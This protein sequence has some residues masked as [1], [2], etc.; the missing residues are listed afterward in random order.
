MHIAINVGRPTLG[1]HIQT[2]HA[3]LIPLR[4]NIKNV[5]LDKAC[6]YHNEPFKT[7]VDVKKLLISRMKLIIKK[8]TQ[9]KEYLMDTSTKT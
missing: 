1:K 9:I 8:I 4:T 6:S 5:G 3:N 7:A 2:G